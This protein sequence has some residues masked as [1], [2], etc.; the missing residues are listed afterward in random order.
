MSSLLVS[1]NIRVLEE[2]MKKLKEQ[3]D[4]I[5]TEMNRL[6]G[7]LRVFKNLQEIGVE[8]IQVPKDVVDNSEVID[9][10]N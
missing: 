9:T 5:K 4:L 1:E 2:N 6:E 7:S 3:S 8:N 10:S